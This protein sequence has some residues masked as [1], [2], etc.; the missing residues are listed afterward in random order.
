VG[1]GTKKTLVDQ[2][3]GTGDEGQ[4]QGATRGRP[5]KEQLATRG[6]AQLEGPGAKP[7]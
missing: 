5:G 4:R 3:I 6:M 2:V 7:S 1:G